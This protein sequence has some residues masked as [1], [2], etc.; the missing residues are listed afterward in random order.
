MF[1][2]DTDNHLIQR[3]LQ[4]SERAWLSLVRRYEKRV[5]NL[6]LRLCG[7]RQDALDLTQE[8]FLAVYRNLPNYRGDGVFVG[9]LLRIAS[10]R[11]VD[12]L[13]RRH[14]NP[15]HAAG[16]VDDEHSDH[17]NA[18]EATEQQRLR[19]A[20]NRQMQQLSPEQRVV[21]ELKFFQHFTFEEIAAQIG[22]P[23]NTAKT[24][25][26]SAL[27]KLRSAEELQHAL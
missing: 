5:Y 13:R 12:F 1:G 23:E 19:A 15:L 25:L 11:G 2:L 20:L 6:C 26:Y 21:V 8:A 24:R 7:N 14:S 9:W 16:E 27:S 17:R 10:H 22:I 3:A 18:S 4:G